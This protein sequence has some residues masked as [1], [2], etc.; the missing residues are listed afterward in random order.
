MSKH[1]LESS[2]S[3]RS[4]GHVNPLWHVTWNVPPRMR[5]NGRSLGELCPQYLPSGV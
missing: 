4:R 1:C 2:F 3:L 5:R